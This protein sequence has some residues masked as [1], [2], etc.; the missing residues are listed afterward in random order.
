MAEHGV[1]GVAIAAMVASGAS[2]MYGVIK[3]L[4]VVLILRYDKG[5]MDG[6]TALDMKEVPEVLE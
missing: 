1:S 2:L 6:D 3:K 4:M 5:R